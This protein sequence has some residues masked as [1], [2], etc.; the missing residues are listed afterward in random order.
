[1]DEIAADEASTTSDEK[2]LHLLSG[3]LYSEAKFPGLA[4]SLG[5][6]VLSACSFG[7]LKGTAKMQRQFTKWGMESQ[8]DLLARTSPTMQNQTEKGIR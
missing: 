7:S 2:I 1:M 6:G 3:N 5:K 4:Q 8:S